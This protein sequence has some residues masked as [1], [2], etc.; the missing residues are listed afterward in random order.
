MR[1]GLQD[2]VR[3]RELSGSKDVLTISLLF[4]SVVVND[5]AGVFRGINKYSPFWLN[6]MVQIVSLFRMGKLLLLV[7]W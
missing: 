4:S 7:L 3:V 5:F 6:N 1:L 2:P